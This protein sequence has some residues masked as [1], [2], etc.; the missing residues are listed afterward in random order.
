MMY[1]VSPFFAVGYEAVVLGNMG[2][3]GFITLIQVGFASLFRSSRKI[4]WLPACAA[5]YF[6]SLA[7]KVA[8][9]AFV[10]I[11]IA[12]FSLI[13]DHESPLGTVV[14]IV[15]FLYV[16]GV[17]ASVVATIHFKVNVR[18][19]QYTQFLSRPFLLR[20]LVPYGFWTPEVVVRAYGRHIGSFLPGF[21]MY[22]SSYPMVVA[23]VAAVFTH[24][25]PATVSCFVRFLLTSAVFFTAAAML[26]AVRPHRIH[27][28]TAFAA[29]LFVLLGIL[30]VLM[31]IAYLS[32]TATLETA[33]LI[34]CG[35]L[36]LVI[37]CRVVFDGI[38][39]YLEWRHWRHF[40]EQNRD[41]INDEGVVGSANDRNT[42]DY[43][44]EF[45]GAEEFVAPPTS[46]NKR[47]PKADTAVVP[48][49]ELM[50]DEAQVAMLSDS[51]SSPSSPTTE[52]SASSSKGSGSFTGSTH[53]SP[54][55]VSS[56]SSSKPIT[57][58]A[59]NTTMTETT[60]E[61]D[62]PSSSPLSSTPSSSSESGYSDASDY[63]EFNL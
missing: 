47:R 56:G 32:P 17:P 42:L 62:S 46:K 16:V 10:G 29:T 23:G 63:S 27:L 35:I 24:L 25:M 43:G 57:S 44:F 61:A 14:G 2:I 6:P 45:G 30:S 11:V 40:R 51:E 4:P 9:F 37:V 20:L 49:S 13:R 3:V 12:A 60:S 18:M 26:A 31:A 19:V 36:V 59:S 22:L 39:T 38:T 54:N 1:I 48:M 53:S 21:R 50:M 58:T 55:A 15:G 5:V 8:E 28:S 52:E 41:A 34:V 33:K 7:L